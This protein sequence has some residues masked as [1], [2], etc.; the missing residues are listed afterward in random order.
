MN[1]DVNNADMTTQL[2]EALELLHFAFRAIVLE[3]DAILAKEK[4]GRAHHRI[5]FMLG[6]R[7]PVST[8]ELVRILGVT[9]Q[10]L[11]RP[12]RELVEKGFVV[13]RTSPDYWRMTLHSLTRKGAALEDKLSG[14]QRMQFKAAFAEVGEAGEAHWRDVMRSIGGALRAGSALNE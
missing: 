3:P 12:L 1:N 13:S 10:S 9:R 5:L 4:M 11:N 7:G 14:L 8:T 6:R 2:N